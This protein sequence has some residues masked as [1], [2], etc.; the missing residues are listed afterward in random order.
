MHEDVIERCRC[1]PNLILRFNPPPL[2]CSVAVKV[3]AEKEIISIPKGP[4]E[5]RP[6]GIRL[7]RTEGDVP[8]AIA[9]DFLNLA[10]FPK[11]ELRSAWINTVRVF[12]IYATRA[13]PYW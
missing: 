8:P 13:H 7:Y 6:P 1:T 4:E 2:F 10:D 11:G 9:K 3:K 5:Y 12:S